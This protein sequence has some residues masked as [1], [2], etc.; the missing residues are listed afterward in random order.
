MINPDRTVGLDPE[1]IAMASGGGFWIASEEPDQSERL[2]SARS[3]AI[4][5]SS[6]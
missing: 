5:S 1:G 4:T 2:E 3:R 6:R